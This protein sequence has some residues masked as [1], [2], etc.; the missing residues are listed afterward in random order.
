MKSA[1]R[2][3]DLTAEDVMKGELVTVPRW[4]PL[5]EVAALLR[6]HQISG[7]PVVDDQ[8]DCVGVLTAADFLRWAEDGCPEAAAGPVRCCGFQKEGR[9]LT[10]EE[11]VICTLAPGS[12]PLQSVQPTTAGRHTAV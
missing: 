7:A 8:G 9:L 5:R 4:A 6:G 10:G 1:E 2:L 11:A 3:L 12:C